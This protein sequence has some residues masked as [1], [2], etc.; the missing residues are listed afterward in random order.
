[1][2]PRRQWLGLAATG[3]AL[4]VAPNAA[5]AAEA[6]PILTEGGLNVRALLEAGGAIGYLIIAL[7]IAMVALIVEH[8]LSIRRGSLMP[9]GFA[10]ACRQLVTASQLTQAGQLCQERPS[11]LSYVV[12]AGLQEASVG[13]DSVEKS[14]EDAAAE[15]AARLFRKIEYLSVI[16]TIAPML[17]LMGTVWGM[18]QAFGEFSNKANPQVAEF[19]PGI[20]HALVTTLFGLLVAIPSLAAFAIFRNRIDEYV[21]ETSLQAE[22]VLQPLKQALKGRSRVAASPA[23]PAEAATAPRTPP[24]SVTRDRETPR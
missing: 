24:P 17:G 16:G 14:M 2:I 5:V 19:A 4:L 22:H 6:A 23:R 9:P 20:S 15:Q 10:D 12:G 1:M 8:L 18:I 11:F 13:Y 3:A 21:A 7:S